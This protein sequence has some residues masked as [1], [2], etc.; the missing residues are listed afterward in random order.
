MKL[1]SATQVPVRTQAPANAAANATPSSTPEVSH[2]DSVSISNKKERMSVVLE[3]IKGAA[4]FG[5]PAAIGAVEN[6]YL[7]KAVGTLAIL[8]N[9]GFGA[10]FG[11]GAGAIHGYREA[12]ENYPNFPG[13]LN[14]AGIPRAGLYG[15][16]GGL[17]GAI[18]GAVLPL[19]G[20][21]GGTT[22][23]AIAT[24][25]GAGLGVYFAIKE[26]RSHGH[27]A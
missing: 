16:F 7:G 5:I 19:A 22:G 2:Q 4:A 11:I 10:M 14:P 1:A 24:A 27:L 23:A 21:Y 9:A 6:H 3:G 8:P 12:T 13:G 17:G 20:I 26:N 25:G 18:G 15:F